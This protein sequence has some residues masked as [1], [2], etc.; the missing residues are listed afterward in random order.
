MGI[1]TLFLFSVRA[2]GGGI[3]IVPRC[4]PGTLAT[5]PIATVKNDTAKRCGDEKAIVEDNGPTVNAGL[6]KNPRLIH[7]PRHLL[8]R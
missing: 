7:L 2:V 4:A 3:A 8:N 1:A 5:N 6:V